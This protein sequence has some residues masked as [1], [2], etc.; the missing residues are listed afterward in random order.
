MCRKVLEHGL[1]ECVCPSDFPKNLTES[2]QALLILDSDI[3]ERKLKVVYARVLI[4]C[5]SFAG[6]NS[7]ASAP[8]RRTRVA[9]LSPRKQ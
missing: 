6:W 5:S 1:R 2:D 7:Q 9:G 8:S 3:S 4:T